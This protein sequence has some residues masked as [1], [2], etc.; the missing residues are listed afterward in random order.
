MFNSRFGD[1]IGAVTQAEL[2][3]MVR[4]VQET[5]NKKIN[6]ELLKVQKSL[7]KEQKLTNDF[8]RQLIEALEK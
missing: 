5:E 6:D 1:Q 4:L 8:L 2:F 3:D 7:L